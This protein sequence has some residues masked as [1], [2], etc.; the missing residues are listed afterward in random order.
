[1]TALREQL[2]Q[3]GF[4]FELYQQGSRVCAWIKGEDQDWILVDSI[5]VEH[6]ATWNAYDPTN[7]GFTPLMEGEG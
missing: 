5:A 2:T 1:M 6:G 4:D 7:L 3:A